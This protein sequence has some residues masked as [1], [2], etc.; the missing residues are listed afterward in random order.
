M[1]EGPLDFPCPTCAAIPGYPCVLTKRDGQPGRIGSCIQSFHPS[2][3]RK[4]NGHNTKKRGYS[5]EFTPRTEKRYAFMVD[6]VPATLHANV[7]A[8][9]KREGV[10]VRAL[11]LKL[12]EQW[13][14]G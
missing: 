14:K 13:L 8:K 3:V 2:R 6:R 4:A 11:I 5:R 1:S 12:L 10:S 9:A 7:T